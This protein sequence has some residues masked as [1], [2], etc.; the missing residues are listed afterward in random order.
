MRTSMT[1]VCAAIILTLASASSARAQ[2][3]MC[4]ASATNCRN[5]LLGLINNEHVGIDVG[6]WFMKDDRYATALVN[7]F[8]RGVRIRIIMDPR[9][10]A[11]APENPGEL[12]KLAAAGIPMRKRIAGDI[13]HWKL[14]IFDGQGE[15]E[16][17]GANFS[18][19][20]F[21]PTEPYVNYEDEVI[22]Y[23]HQLVGS[24]MTKFD[25]IWTNTK[26]YA[27]YANVTQALTRVHPTYP[28]DTR[29]NF[30]P[31]SSYISRLVPLID[32]EPKGGL[33][34]V[35]MYRITMTA[36]VDALIR[37]A[38]R[39]VRQRL[40]LEPNEYNNPQRPGNKVQEDRL[41]AAALKYPGTIEIRMRAHDGL[42][43]Q[44]TIWLH[45]QHI[46]VFGTSNW[47]DASDDNQL[48]ANIFTD[49]D[50]G[51]GINS[52]LFG[53]LQT[54]FVRKFYNRA[55]DGSIETVA[56]R[57]PSLPEP[58]PDGP[59]PPPPP[60]PLPLPAPW[61]HQDIGGVAA[62]GGASYNSST[63][64]FTVTASGADIWGAAD[65]FHYV[66]QPWTGDGSIV[67]RVADVTETDSW[68]KAGVMLRATLD[69]SS[70]HA[71]MLV[72]A[73]R[74]AAFQRR[75]LAG[76]ASVSTSGSAAAPPRWVRLDRTGDTF[77]A[78]ESADG[79]AWTLVR[80][81][82]IAMPQTIYAGLAAVS[83]ADGRLTSAA[84]DS[85]KITATGGGGGSPLPSPWTDQDIGAVGPAGGAVFDATTSTFTVRGSG[86][87]VWGSADA[88]NYASQPW[89]GDG[90]IVAHVSAV[91][92]TN[93]WAKAGVMFRA[94]LDA[95]SAQAFMVVSA[96]KGSAFQRR[97]TAG[98]VSVSTSG[99]TAAPPRWVRLDRSGDLFTAY[100]SADGSVWT[101][102]G[103]ETI[104]MPSTIHVGLATTSHDNTKVT[105]STIDSVTVT[106]AGGGGTVGPPP[107]SVQ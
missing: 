77:T 38:A 14:M 45:A 76:G 99:T 35:D 55:P 103:S 50:P 39:G 58:P 23:S 26:E 80:S 105:T 52:L 69:A 49:R 102:V 75:L 73:A 86:A 27:N 71:F 19:D 40:Y 8:K 97:P 51:D 87:D 85:V 29:L 90:S 91:T 89:T 79:A 78:Y 54:I 60:P 2:E 6:M 18:P 62:P 101:V 106:Q 104:A 43:H 74:G 17:S 22:Y 20:A 7:A 96:G 33:I 57:T 61:S 72:S 32:N 5:T 31:A 94:T 98:G 25:D 15:V 46:V 48:E 84:I 65:A 93:A 44:K 107:V 64:T 83:H 56:W 53:D 24:F 63:S 81:E 66:W 28:V 16:W 4:D 12:D 13:C 11:S 37:A 34:D 47:S 41:V 82:A 88:F 95:S 70:A 67:A 1:A 3:Q 42:N 30:P 21:V 9:A 68:S 36:P 10:N 59:P 100:E 92:N